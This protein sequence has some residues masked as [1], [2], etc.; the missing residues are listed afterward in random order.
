MEPC[1]RL[2][3]G[4]PARLPARLTDRDMRILLKAAS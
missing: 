3:K 4:M 1:K 2:M